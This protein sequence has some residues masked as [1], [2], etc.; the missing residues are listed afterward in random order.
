MY[1]A[2]VT[3]QEFPFS[4]VFSKSDSELFQKFSYRVDICQVL[5][6][7]TGSQPGG[8]IIRSHV[9]VA[10]VRSSPVVRPSIAILSLD[11]LDLRHHLISHIAPRR[12]ARW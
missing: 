3:R 11:S 10:K 1:Y 6:L 2:Y 8:K 12:V 5:P 7:L 4:D 9:I